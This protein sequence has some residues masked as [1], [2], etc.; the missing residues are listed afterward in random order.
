MYRGDNNVL[1]TLI[2]P[3]VSQVTM[4][5]RCRLLLL[6]AMMTMMMEIINAEEPGKCIPQPKHKN[7]KSKKPKR[8]TTLLLR[9]Y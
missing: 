5:T 8:L 4:E 6:V 7:S 2:M 3:C 9:L 1:T